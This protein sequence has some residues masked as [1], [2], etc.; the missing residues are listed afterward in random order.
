M[1][2]YAGLRRSEI[3]GLQ[4]ENYDGQQITVTRSM[5]EGHVSKPK[6]TASKA[7]VPV[8][9]ALRQILD[10]YSIERGN[11]RSGPMFKSQAKANTPL[12]MNNV[13][14]RMILP[15][16]NRCEVCRK[17]KDDHVGADHKYKR[18]AT[19]PKW[20]GWHAFRRGLA[21]N[22][23]DL[24]IDDKTIQAILRHANVSMTQR[25]YIKTLPKQIIDAMIG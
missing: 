5:W 21:T 6:T 25:C 24:G 23:H 4:W 14:N 19:L 20:H 3:A 7:P 1:A 8:I 22:L 2:A 9:G 11:P 18:D 17:G 10:M 12:S 13:L 16:L 15:A